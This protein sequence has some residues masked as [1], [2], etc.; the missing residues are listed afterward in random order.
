MMKKLFVMLLLCMII[1]TSVFAENK[2][3]NI[4][5]GEGTI[6]SPIQTEDSVESYTETE[7]SVPDNWNSAAKRWIGKIRRMWLWNWNGM[8]CGLPCR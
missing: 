1:V 4:E 2:E 6:E 5:Q 8:K 7:G 3:E